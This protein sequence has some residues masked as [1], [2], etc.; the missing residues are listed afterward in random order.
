MTEIEVILTEIRRSVEELGGIDALYNYTGLDRKKHILPAVSIGAEYAEGIPAGFYSYLG[1]KY[2]KE[3]DTY[4]EI[5]GKRLNLTIS[6]DIR[7]PASEKGG[8]GCIAVFGRIASAIDD[9]GGIK[10]KEMSC[11]EVSYDKVNDSYFCRS[12]VLITAFL[13]T[14]REEDTEEFTDF[15][16]KGEMT[17]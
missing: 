2:Y 3:T 14:S 1:T 16:L 11:G 15:T 7:C 12:K 8:G 9:I 13:Y 17:R 6:L 5:Y 4:A 10:V